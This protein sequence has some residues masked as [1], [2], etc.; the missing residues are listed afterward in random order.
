MT[1][2]DDRLRTESRSITAAQPRR[3]LGLGT[4]FP[5]F[6]VLYATV[7]PRLEAPAVEFLRW[8]LALGAKSPVDHDTAFY[9]AFVAASF[10]AT[11]AI[12]AFTERFA[13][14]IGG[15]ADHYLLFWLCFFGTFAIV[16]LLWQQAGGHAEAAKA[17]FPLALGSLLGI[18]QGFVRR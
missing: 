5:L 2:W 9:F 6:L 1:V 16:A 10:I 14:W 18:G 8:A 11:T 15:S 13:T 12:T 3:L 7:A 4:A 17:L